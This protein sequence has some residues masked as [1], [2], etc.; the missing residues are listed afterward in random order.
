MPPED[1]TR[2]ACSRAQS[3]FVL[4]SAQRKLTQSFYKRLVDPGFYDSE[5]ERVRL[6]EELEAVRVPTEIWDTS[7]SSRQGWVQ[8]TR[9]LKRFKGKPTI[10]NRPKEPPTWRSL[11]GNY[12]GNTLALADCAD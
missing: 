2:W 7:V 11:D 5:L 10:I 9:P 6:L 3:W 12:Y 8:G 4:T 1:Q